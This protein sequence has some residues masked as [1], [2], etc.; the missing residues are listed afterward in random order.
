MR[1]LLVTY[2]LKQPFANYSGL[3]ETLQTAT[4]WWHYLD[5]TWLIATNETP[6][7]WYNKFSRFIHKNDL[8]LII[9][10]KRNYWGLLPHEAWSWLDENV[11]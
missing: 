1:V 7:E 4:K 3:F 11:R 5:S 8:I 10:V 9:E 2:V 6:K